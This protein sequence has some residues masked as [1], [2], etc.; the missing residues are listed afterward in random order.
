MSVNEEEEDFSPTT[1]LEDEVEST[2]AGF[3]DKDEIVH[4]FTDRVMQKINSIIVKKD[5]NPED[6][7]DSL[8]DSIEQHLSKRANKT[9]SKKT[10]INNQTKRVILKSDFST[11]ITENSTLTTSPEIQTTTSL[12]KTRFSIIRKNSK[13]ATAYNPFKK[14]L[15]FLKMLPRLNYSN[16]DERKQLH[17]DKLDALLN[18]SSR[19]LKSTTKE[20]TTVE[21]A[22]NTTTQSTPAEEK[23]TLEYEDESIVTRKDFLNTTTQEEKEFNRTTRNQMENSFTTFLSRIS[24]TPTVYTTNTTSFIPM[25]TNSKP[26]MQ[27]Y[28]IN[29]TKKL[30]NQFASLRLNYDHENVITKINEVERG[31]KFQRLRL[32]PSDTLIECKENDFGLE[33]SCS[34]TLSPP[35][36]KQLINSF[37]SSCK[38]LGCKNNGKCI[39]MA[40]KYPIPYVCSCPS[41]FMGSYC[42]LPRSS[43][44]KNDFLNSRMGYPKSSLRNSSPD[45]GF[46]SSIS[47]SNSTSAPL[48]ATTVKLTM[49]DYVQ[50]ICEPNPC[51]NNGKC[52]LVKE[53][54][55]CK[56]SNSS[57]T[58]KFCEKFRILPIRPKVTALPSTIQILTT[59]TTSTSDLPTNSTISK[60]ILTIEEKFNSTKSIGSTTRAYF[61][62]CPSNCFHSLGHGYCSM[63]STGH[64][65][66]VCRLEWTG[67]DCS[68]RNYCIINKCENNSTCSNYPEMK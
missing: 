34:I 48:P 14:P 21:L 4:E 62:Q 26:S 25:Y 45:F 58:G 6:E 64:P 29:Q 3:L 16:L 39:N 52:I 9:V 8:I 22:L 32:V 35:K 30:P 51:L 19:R 27:T 11:P 20:Y 65:Y 13:P 41:E 28:K 1:L 57:F 24:S 18:F 56:C 59:S 5:I 63:S 40:Y 31:G 47:N 7:E 60:N 33:C 68:Q 2:D 38:I 15:K 54:F 23:N 67:I 17:F 53:D 66:C 50:S 44:V 42:E 55:E 43:S 36:C 46:L 61:W 12:P 37:L 49:S 10:L